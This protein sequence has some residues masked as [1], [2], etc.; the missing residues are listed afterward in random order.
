MLEVLPEEKIVEICQNMDDA[1]LSRFLNTSATN[2][3][4]CSEVLDKRIKEYGS[5]FEQAN[6]TWNKLFPDNTLSQIYFFKDQ[7]Q[8]VQVDDK[9]YEAPIVKS[10]FPSNITVSEHLDLEAGHIIIQRSAK[11][12]S[13][14][15]LLIILKRIQQRGYTKV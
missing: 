6:V 12:L 13:T 7:N 10:I 2:Y 9:F 14:N 8:V 5:L 15:D 4:I 11:N 1:T 3:R